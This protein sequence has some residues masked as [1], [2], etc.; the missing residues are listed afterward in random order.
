MT[1]PS[2]AAGAI[3]AWATPWCDK[4]LPPGATPNEERDR[5]R[6]FG[7]GLTTAAPGSAPALHLVVD[8]VT[9]ARAELADRGR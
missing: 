9:A 8:D 4:G 3:R 7:T 5:R 6:N 2:H 1:T